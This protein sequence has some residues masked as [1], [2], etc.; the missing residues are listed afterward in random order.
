[1]NYLDIA[2][3]E[4]HNS[5]IIAIADVSTYTVGKAIDNPFIEISPPGF[6]KVSLT[7]TPRSVNVFNSTSLK[8]TAG[9]VKPA[10]LPDG[11][12]KIRY[13]IRPNYENF[14]EKNILRISALKERFDRA[15][16]RNDPFSC[17]V[18]QAGKIS[19][20]LDMIS[21]YLQYAMAAAGICN[22]HLAMDLYRK[23]SRLLE[24]LDC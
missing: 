15:F 9:E 6:G 7:F 13:S 8:L 1:M 16:L 11:I 2:I 4:A 5:Q 24:K 22:D 3:V 21:F 10:V 20:K 19:S 18:R 17:S 23:A 14:V 12:Y